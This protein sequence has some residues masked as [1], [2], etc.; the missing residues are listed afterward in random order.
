M[1]SPYDIIQ[2]VVK[3]SDDF[4]EEH[5]ITLGEALNIAAKRMRARVAAR[6]HH[7]LYGDMDGDTCLLSKCALHH[8]EN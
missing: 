3:I 5:G 7:R 8:P 1:K 4:Y 2:A 6:K